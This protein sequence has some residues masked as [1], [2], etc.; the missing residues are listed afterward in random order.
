MLPEKGQDEPR[1]NAEKTSR[2][3]N[4]NVEKKCHYLSEKSYGELMLTQVTIK[5]SSQS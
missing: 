1:E 4:N 3:G 2:D 5:P